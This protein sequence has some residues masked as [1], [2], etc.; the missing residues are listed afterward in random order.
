M[1]LKIVL[2]KGIFLLAA[3]LWLERRLEPSA[4]R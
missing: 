3:P 4:F 1:A 2:N